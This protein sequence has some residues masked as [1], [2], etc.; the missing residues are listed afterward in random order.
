MP[1]FDLHCV[2]CDK[3]QEVLCRHS[4][5]AE[6]K[7]GTCGEALKQLPPAKTTFRLQGSGWYD[8]EYNNRRSPKN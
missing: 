5:I 6:Q 7:C 2:K 8:V 4:Q 1:L 3:K